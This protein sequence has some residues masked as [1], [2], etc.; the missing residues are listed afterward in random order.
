MEM[1]IVGKPVAEVELNLDLFRKILAKSWDLEKAVSNSSKVW[2]INEKYK[3]SDIKKF[4][5]YQLHWGDIIS[6]FPSLKNEKMDIKLYRVRYSKWKKYCPG[7]ISDNCRVFKIMEIEEAK[8]EGFI[9]IQSLIK[10]PSFTI[11]NFIDN[12]EF[13][14]TT[15]KWKQNILH[16]S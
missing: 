14:Y 15:K 11:K 3:K 1:E 7:S 13:T 5:R 12:E 9:L 10:N 8:A 16:L 6:V 4:I 2:K